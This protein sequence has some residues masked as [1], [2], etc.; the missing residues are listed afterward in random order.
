MNV[1]KETLLNLHFF[2][3]I[4]PKENK[5]IIL[6]FSLLLI[7]VVSPFFQDSHMARFYF[8]FLISLVL[9]TSFYADIELKRIDYIELLLGGLALFFTWLE[10]FLPD[11]DTI[12]FLTQLIYALFFLYFTIELIS[13]ITISNEVSANLIYASIVGFLMLGLCGA[14]L[15]SLLQWAVANAYSLPQNVSAHK[16]EN[17]IYYSFVTITTVG[18]GDMLPIHPASKM[19]AI[20]LCIS[21]HFYTTIVLALIIGKFIS[22][23]KNSRHI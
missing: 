23:N 20:L 18:Y 10:F 5:Y 22:G 17:F 21:G 4:S 14:S 12:D 13:K 2:H 7:M 9:A 16:F 15:A 3:K 6:L 11:I 8:S 1:L 19:L